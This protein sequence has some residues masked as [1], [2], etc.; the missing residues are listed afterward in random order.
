MHLAEISRIVFL[1]DVARL[2]AGPQWGPS[3][4]WSGIGHE[5]GGATPSIDDV[6]ELDQN[7][8]PHQGDDATVVFSDYRAGKIFPGNTRTRVGLLFVGRRHDP[9]VAGERRA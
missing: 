8:V 4:I 7:A 5:V 3:R 1:A 6:R 2:H 9:G